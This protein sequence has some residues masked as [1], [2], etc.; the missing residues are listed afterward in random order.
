MDII[1]SL[2]HLYY[3]RSALYLVCWVWRDVSLCV[4]CD[5]SCL[6]VLASTKSVLTPPED[7]TFV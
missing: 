1:Y 4:H 2:N 5:R 7:A 6:A 3:T